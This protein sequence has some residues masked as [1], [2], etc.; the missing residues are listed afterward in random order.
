MMIV[1]DVEV[2]AE[3]IPRRK[4]RVCRGEMVSLKV[5]QSRVDVM[6]NEIEWNDGQGKSKR[7]WKKTQRKGTRLWCE[8]SHRPCWQVRRGCF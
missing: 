4:M 1:I 2:E 7:R 8:I 6:Q 5:Q 3:V